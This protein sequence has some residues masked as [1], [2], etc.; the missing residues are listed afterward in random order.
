MLLIV[1]D[2]VLVS[3]LELEVELVLV[4]L[5]GVEVEVGKLGVG[6]DVEL[7]L[8]L[9]LG[10]VI[11]VGV[12]ETGGRLEELDVVVVVGVVV[13][14]VIGVVVGAVPSP[15]DTGKKA[16]VVASESIHM[17]LPWPACSTQRAPCS[18][19]SRLSLQFPGCMLSASQRRIIFVD[20]LDP[21]QYATSP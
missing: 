5:L 13:G 21:A 10:V 16:V 1:D 20:P 11:V 18:G 17:A 12:I 14:V 7:E 15:P 9:E 6:L 8:R 19:S 2:V 3:L 4:V